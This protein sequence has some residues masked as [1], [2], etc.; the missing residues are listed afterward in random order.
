MS[1][2]YETVKQNITSGG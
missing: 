2:K 1:A